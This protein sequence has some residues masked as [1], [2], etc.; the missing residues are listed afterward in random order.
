VGTPV[1]LNLPFKNNLEVNMTKIKSLILGSA[2]GLIAIGGAQ[3]ADLPVKAKAVEYVKICSLYGAG[4]YYIPGTD[5]C[6][7][8]GGQIRLDTTFNG[9]TYDTPYIQGGAGGNNLYTKDYVHT[10]ARIGLNVDTRTA[11]E[12]GVVRT[13]AD[14]KFQFTQNG[15]SIA[16]G[17]TETDYVF[18]QFAGF[19]I[20]KAVSQFDPQW[21]LSKP[22]ISSGMFFGSND[23]TGI[24]Q[25]AYT[26]SFGNGVSGT[27]SLENA[28]PYRNAG[29]YNSA[30][31]IVGPGAGGTFTSAGGGL[32]GNYGST[33]NNFLGN[34]QGGNH[35][36]DIVGNIRL[37]QAWGSLH[38]GAAVHQTVGGFYGANELTGHPD[39]AYGYAFTGAIEIKNLPTGAGDRFLLEASYGK[40]AA[41]YVWGGTVDTAGGGRFAKFDSGNTLAFGYVLDGVFAPGGQIQQSNSW[42]VSAFYEHYWTPQWRTS[43]FGNYN[44]IDYGA[45]GNAILAAAFSPAGGR[46][47]TSAI[48]SIPTALPATAVG[49]ATTAG[50][51]TGTTGD[52]SFNIAQIGTRTAWTPVKDLTFSAEFSYSYLDQNLGGTYNVIAGTAGKAA[53]AYTLRDQNVYSGSVQA[54][55]SF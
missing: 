31:F 54:L 20:G 14:T 26:A 52:F 46:L 5:T 28:S 9:G 55:R 12:Y 47:G 45:G 35:M 37:D 41:K 11:T 49:F 19:T 18:I 22:T 50:T 16:G 8:I 6:I 25:L 3:A 42:E 15:D 7:K 53:G 2:A 10:R 33:S 24:P 23:A 43:V 36:P 44:H 39:D 32:S 1:D 38:F 29:L 17:F 27:I 40:G 51:L 4:F 30:N 34:S 21:A 13:F 48:P